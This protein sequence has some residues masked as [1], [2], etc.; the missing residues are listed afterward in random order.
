MP[1]NQDSQ[2]FDTEDARRKKKK[3][4]QA[5]Y[6]RK[7]RGLLDQLR[8]R[9]ARPSN[10][11]SQILERSID[12]ID[13][14]RNEIET[15]DSLL[16]NENINTSGNFN[17]QGGIETTV[18]SRVTAK[19]APSRASFSPDGYYIGSQGHDAIPNYAGDWW[20]FCMPGGSN[21]E[22]IMRDTCQSSESYRQIGFASNDNTTQN[23][24]ADVSHGIYD[25]IVPVGVRCPDQPYYLPSGVTE[26]EMYAL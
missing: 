5:E 12:L 19:D 1:V 3:K 11:D 8:K 23:F 4:M 17:N 13:K 26:T 24:H 15:L 21:A 22:H 7:K 2:K 20:G 18:L 6:R 10:S 14:Q 9:I 25:A 16:R